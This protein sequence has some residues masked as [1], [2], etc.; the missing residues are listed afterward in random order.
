MFI[1]KV[2]HIAKYALVIFLLQPLA[3]LSD[4]YYTGDVLNE[5]FEANVHPI[6]DEFNLSRNSSGVVTIEGS[7]VFGNSDN[8]FTLNVGPDGVSLVSV[9]GDTSFAFNPEQ[10]E[11]VQ[12]LHLSLTVSG[13][14]PLSVSPSCDSLLLA[15]L[16]ESFSHT[17]ASGE[18]PIE[19]P[20]DNAGIFTLGVKIGAVVTG[21]ADFYA[22]LEIGGFESDE[23]P[24]DINGERRPD[25]LFASITPSISG[26]AY[27]K[28]YLK[29]NF[30]VTTVEKGVTGSM[31]LIDAQTNA[32]T[33]TVVVRNEDDTYD[34]STRFKWDVSATGGEGSIDLYCQVKL[35]NRW[36]IVDETRNLM[37]WSSIW[38]INETIFDQTYSL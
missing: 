34:A 1:S 3:A 19:V 18:I 23:R 15:E 21:S 9:F 2:S 16:S 14:T 38:E 31:N 4:T 29:A 26:S 12:G 24:I 36:T 25:R 6:V 33:E 22:A 32:F 13:S 30:F 11:C 37:N 27:A 28:G 17:F 7:N 35:F 10:L 8:N 20:I 5:A